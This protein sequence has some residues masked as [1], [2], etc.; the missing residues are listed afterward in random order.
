MYSGVQT[1]VSAKSLI[2]NPYLTTIV[3]D[4]E[5]VVSAAREFFD[6]PEP[7][8]VITEDPSIWVQRSAAQLDEPKFDVVIHDAFE[9]GEMPA[10]LFTMEFWTALRSIMDVQGVIAVVS[11]TFIAY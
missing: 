11:R 4:K 9:S 7:E 8:R 5:G 1:G 6:L 2:S 3:D 10:K